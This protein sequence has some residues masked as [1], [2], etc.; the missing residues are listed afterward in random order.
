MVTLRGYRAEEVGH[1][2]CT[3]DYA[4]CLNGNDCVLYVP[5]LASP[6]NMAWDRGKL[7]LSTRS[8]AAVGE[9]ER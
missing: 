8:E 1:I 3:R 9:S 4:L 2:L 5:N 6:I 7:K